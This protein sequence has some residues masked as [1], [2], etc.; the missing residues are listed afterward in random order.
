[1]ITR[2]DN[3]EVAR[4]SQIWAHPRAVPRRDRGPRCPPRPASPLGGPAGGGGGWPLRRLEAEPGRRRGRC[5][6]GARAATA[7]H[8]VQ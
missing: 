7:G 5:H 6:R 8:H 4:A 1:M 2:K 3:P